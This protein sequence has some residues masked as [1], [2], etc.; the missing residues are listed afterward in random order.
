[1]LNPKPQASHHEEPQKD[2]E[3][4]DEGL[5]THGQRMQEALKR[6]NAKPFRKSF[7]KM[8][9]CIFVGYLCSATNGFDSNTFGEYIHCP[10]ERRLMCKSVRG[11]VRYG[12]FHKLLSY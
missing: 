10:I 1:M 12:I 6:D 9:L 11:F 3:Y 8:Y 4:G 5:S 7:L 2:V